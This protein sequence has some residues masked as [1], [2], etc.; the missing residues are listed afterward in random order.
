MEKRDGLPLVRFGLKEE[1]VYFNHAIL[2]LLKSPR[3]VQFLYEENRKILLVSGNN[4]KLPYS[5][6]VPKKVYQQHLKDFR[7]CHKMLTEAFIL[8]LGWDRNENYSV[9][10]MLEPNI[11]MVVFE[12]EKAEKTG[13]EQEDESE[14]G[15]SEERSMT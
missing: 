10:G 1:K 11:N 4:D 2:T 13:L 8:R 5:L 3:Y 14:L 6:V 7:I 15:E 12:L 9:T